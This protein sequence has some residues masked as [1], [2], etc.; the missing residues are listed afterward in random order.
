MVLTEALKM[1]VHQKLFSI[2][3]AKAKTKFSFNL[4]CSG[5]NGDS[6]VS[7]NNL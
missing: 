4:H 1:E 7:G 6:F 3:F 2:N 5:N